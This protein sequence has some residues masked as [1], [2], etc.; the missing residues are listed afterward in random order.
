MTIFFFSG[1]GGYFYHSC[2]YIKTQDKYTLEQYYYI[3]IYKLLQFGLEGNKYNNKSLIPQPCS[4][5]CN[6]PKYW[7]DHL[8]GNYSTSS[9]QDQILSIMYLYYWQVL[10]SFE[11][12]S[13]GPGN[14]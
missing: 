13:V 9:D 10:V 6:P 7:A 8:S 4:S 12:F 2:L 1:G 5:L 3:A 14:H 11:W